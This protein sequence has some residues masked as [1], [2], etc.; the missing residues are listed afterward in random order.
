MFHQWWRTERDVARGRV[1]MYAHGRHRWCGECL[2]LL[3][4]SHPKDSRVLTTTIS[5]TY[6]GFIL[7]GR[8]LQDFKP[9]LSSTQVK[10][11]ITFASLVQQSQRKAQSRTNRKGKSFTQ[12]PGTGL[13][14]HW[15]L[16]CFQVIWSKG[17]LMPELSNPDA[18]ESGESW[19]WRRASGGVA[20]G[21]LELQGGGFKT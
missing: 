1:L 11:L 18:L 3:M 9:S 14:V 17:K 10:E 21:I 2:G 5:E 20:R 6:A 15:Y 7:W 16:G 13:V 12:E 4:M 19:R 8:S